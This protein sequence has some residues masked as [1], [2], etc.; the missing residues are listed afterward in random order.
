MSSQKTLIV[1]GACGFIGSN[2]VRQAVR[3]GQRIIVLDALTYAGHRENI[4]GIQGP[5]SVELA[6][7]DICDPLLIQSLFEKNT[8]HALV[9]F[10]AESHVDRSI[11]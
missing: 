10:A 3:D 7:G 11:S 1:T 4:E 8:V 2:F 5:G 9:N 6:E